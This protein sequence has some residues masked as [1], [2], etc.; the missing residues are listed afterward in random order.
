MLDGRAKTLFSDT[1]V[2]AIGNIAV[3]LVQFALLPLYTACMSVEQYGISELLNTL[4]E[5][6]YPIV[7]LGLYEAMFRFS[8]DDDC[9]KKKLATNAI[10][11]W[12]IGSAV[13]VVVAFAIQA[14]VYQ[15]AICVALLL[16]MY[17]LRSILAQFA[18]GNSLV[19][20][21]AFSGI[22]G[23]VVLLGLSVVLVGILRWE[24][25][26]YLGSMIGSAFASSLYL[27][28]SVGFFRYVGRSVDGAYLK[29]MLAYSLPL[30][31]NSIA[32][33]FN[34][35]SSRFIVQLFCGSGVVGLFIAAS[36]LP[37]IMNF[38][39][40]IFQQAWQLNAV[41]TRLSTDKD[42]YY[43]SVFRMYAVGMILVTMVAV[44][45]SDLL[46]DFLLRGEFYE[47]KCF[48]PMLMI[49]AMFNSF[50]AFLGAFYAAQKE[51]TLLLGST[52]VGALVNVGISILLVVAFGV[53]GAIGGL[54]I[55][56]AV[57]AIYR[58]IESSRFV[59][60]NV[61]K[62]WFICGVVLAVAQATLVTVGMLPASWVVLGVFVVYQVFSNRSFFVR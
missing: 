51:S 23:S 41:K 25:V 26:G 61:F 45:A 44:A 9:D 33:W 38:F 4:N 52:L 31:P 21:F 24:V 40:Q 27:L 2:F 6:A 35:F 17:S 48:V 36:K 37:A 15:Y 7:C 57:I 22:V 3:K 34:N 5:L 19:R 39:I 43:S 14:F 1:A 42:C 13:T 56:N 11:V 60:L 8:M 50:A 55:S 12:L 32:W 47:A 59:S 28:F 46:A 16:C 18:R 30:V 49:S 54:V 53:W 58:F 10:V 62:P 29:R 20:Q